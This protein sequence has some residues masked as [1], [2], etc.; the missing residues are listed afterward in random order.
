MHRQ[1]QMSRQLLH[2]AHILKLAQVT[3]CS[4]F[5]ILIGYGSTWIM[6][7]HLV[8]LE[9]PRMILSFKLYIYRKDRPLTCSCA[10]VLTFSLQL[11]QYLVPLCVPTSGLMKPKGIK[12]QMHSGFSWHFLTLG[13]HYV[14]FPA[15]VVSVESCR[16]IQITSKRNSRET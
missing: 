8:G 10:S 15:V 3:S 6:A 9:M 16:L 11:K 13:G 12:S 5:V 7:C 14:S 4:Q 2:H 1:N